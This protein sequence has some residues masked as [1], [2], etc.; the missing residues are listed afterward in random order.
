MEQ[1]HINK[2]QRNKSSITYCNKCLKQID[3]ND[4]DVV[5]DINGDWFCSSDCRR[6]YFIE[7]KQDFD[8]IRNEFWN[9]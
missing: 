5:R 7:I 9:R 6:D 1:Q 4:K 2:Q 8:D 3:I